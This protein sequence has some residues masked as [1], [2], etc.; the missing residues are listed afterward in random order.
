[1]TNQY[2][3]VFIMTPV[4]SEDQMKETAQKF[5]KII[6]DNGGEIVHQ[7][8]WGMRKLDYPI[9]KKSSGFYH[10]FEFKSEPSFVKEFEIQL[11]RDERIMRYL[12]VSLDKDAIEYNK[13]RR[14]GK[15][16]K[17]NEQE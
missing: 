2:E 13:R 12:T 15:T 9:K 8:N 16:N 1:M 11:K 10:L 14:E 4:L 6:L 5:E 3:A 17:T 7:E